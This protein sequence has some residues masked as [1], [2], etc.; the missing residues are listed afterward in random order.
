LLRHL[1]IKLQGSNFMTH[2][3]VFPFGE[4]AD[5]LTA[6]PDNTALDGSV[7][8]NQGWTPPYEYNLDTNPAALPIPRGQM[9]QLFYDITL[10][11]QQYQQYGVPYWV[12]GNTVEYPIYSR[13][14]YNNLVYENQ[15]VDNTATP[16]DDDTWNVI[17]GSNASLPIG[18]IIDYAG[19]EAPSNFLMCNGN[20]VSRSIYVNLLSAITQLQDGTTTN[21]ANTISGLTSTS[22]LYVGM[23]IEGSGIPVATTISS[24]VDGNNITISQN[25]TAS[26]TVPIRFFN[27]GNGDGSTTFNVPDLRRRTTIGSQGSGSSVI[28]KATGEKGGVESHAILLNE[29]PNHSHSAASGDFLVN[30]GNAIQGGTDF[31]SLQVNTGNISGYSGQTNLSLMQPSAVVSKC[32]KYR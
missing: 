18:S 5:D 7:S 1:I 2:Y 29:I 4:N 25:S 20:A 10:N 31:G 32:I 26:D 11:I 24:I 22:D 27:W 14:Y 8:Y 21:G 13:V 17:S 15:V 16:G 30:T 9:N 23:S 28:G 6:I 12:T 19:V 3:Y